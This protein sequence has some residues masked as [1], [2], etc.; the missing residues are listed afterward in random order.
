[1]RCW[2]VGSLRRLYHAAKKVSARNTIA[3]MSPVVVVGMALGSE[4]C[5]RFDSRGGAAGG[6]R[7]RV[8]F[9]GEKFDQFV[10][11]RLDAVLGRDFLDLGLDLPLLCGDGRNL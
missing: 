11:D 3:R 10:Y 6:L 4:V 5:L 1:M 7:S 2:V 9:S 8:R